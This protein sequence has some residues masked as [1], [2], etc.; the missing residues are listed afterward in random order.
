MKLRT[1]MSSIIRRRKGLMAVSV[2]GLFLMLS[3]WFGNHN[4][5]TGQT[6]P[7]TS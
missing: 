7:V 1:S 2:M 3:S 5:N 6:Q 4:L